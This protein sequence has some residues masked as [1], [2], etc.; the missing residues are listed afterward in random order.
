MAICS[1]DVD[2]IQLFKNGEKI[3][4]NIYE[5]NFNNFQ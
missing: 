4:E 5:T 3:W 2:T 1:D